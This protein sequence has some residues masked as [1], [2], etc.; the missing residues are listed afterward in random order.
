M[1]PS[2]ACQTNKFHQQAYFVR[3]ILCICTLRVWVIGT[4]SKLRRR[5]L[6]QRPEVKSPKNDAVCLLG[7]DLSTYSR[8]LQH[9]DLSCGIVAST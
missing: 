6:L 3:N 9:E 1:A 4:L 5:S 8:I 7:N 2:Y